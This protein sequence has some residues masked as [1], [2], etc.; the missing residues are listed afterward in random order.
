[1]HS[2]QFLT[3]SP[4]HSH[5]ISAFSV[6][7]PRKKF[8]WDLGVLLL[9]VSSP[10]VILGKAEVSFCMLNSFWICDYSRIPLL[11]HVLNP[12][13]FTIVVR[14]SVPLARQF[15]CWTWAWRCSGLQPM[16]SA[17]RAE[18]HALSTPSF[19]G[20][21]F[22]SLMVQSEFQF[23]LRFGFNQSRFSKLV[24]LFQKEKSYCA[25]WWD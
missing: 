11:S 23:S 17:K 24:V 25:K 8:R 6:P 3:H 2:S 1:M 7:L 21:E 15:C 14:T 12:H 13:Y 5:Y 20:R 19:H 22:V 16:A 18:L 10:A 9:F 4:M